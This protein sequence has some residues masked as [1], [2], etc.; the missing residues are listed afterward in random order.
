MSHVMILSSD[1][2]IPEIH[3]HNAF[4]IIK[5]FYD[6]ECSEIERFVKKAYYYEIDISATNL[7]LSELKKF[8]TQITLPGS[9]VE[10][11]SLMLGGDLTKH[12]LSMPR[13]S[14]IPRADLQEIEESI[15]AY[16]EEHFRPKIRKTSIC[17]LTIN[18]IS[19]VANH[20]GVCLI[21]YH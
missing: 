1:I 13:T 7:A 14:N 16:S 19:F 12:Y 20:T 15:D 4:S 5:S 6:R 18:D 21:V 3:K 9:E 2:N 10:L 8:L 17:E 11:W